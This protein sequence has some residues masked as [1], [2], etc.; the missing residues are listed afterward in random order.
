MI[1]SIIHIYGSTSLIIASIN[2]HLDIIQ[3]LVS[4]GANIEAKTN[5]IFII[6]SILM[7]KQQLTMHGMIKSRKY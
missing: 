1:F 7:G 5:L 6:S 4:K 3:Y 2:G